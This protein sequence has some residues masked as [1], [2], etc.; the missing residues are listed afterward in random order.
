MCKRKISAMLTSEFTYFR[1]SWS[2][3][4]LLWELFSHAD[5]PYPNVNVA[6]LKQMLENGE[7]LAKPKKCPTYA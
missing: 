5:N 2:F 1:F 4:V 6:T 7:R 3:G